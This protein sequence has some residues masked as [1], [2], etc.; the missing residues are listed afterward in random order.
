MK[1]TVVLVDD[2]PP[3][4]AGVA[5]ILERSGTYRVVAEVGT[6]DDAFYTVRTL[7]PDVCVLDIS[8][9]D[10]N[11][12]DVVRDTKRVAPDTK[13]LILSMHSVRRIA[14]EA[15][16]AG[17]DGYML[18]ESTGEHLV[19]AL[20][21]ILRGEPFIDARLVPILDGGTPRGA[22]PDGRD[23]V[24]ILSDREYQVFCLLAHGRTSKE[25]GSTLGISP[26]TVDNHRASIM[27]KLGVFSV[28][29][30]VRITIRTGA[31]QP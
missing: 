13:I 16:Q 12:V 17:A 25:I 27:E 18:K 6:A 4:R 10:G 28:A 15:L 21:Q 24:E 23:G 20:D 31:M 30:L 2:H 26:K 5:A 9:P 1:H 22:Q 7:A 8:L 29:D 11:G 3:L 14:D 19:T